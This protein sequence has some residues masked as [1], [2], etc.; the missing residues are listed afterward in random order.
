MN[1]KYPFIPIKIERFK[2]Q[3]VVVIKS[4]LRNITFI[5]HMISSGCLSDHLRTT[6]LCP[7]TITVMH[8]AKGSHGQGLCCLLVLIL[9]I[10]SWKRLWLFVTFVTQREGDKSKYRFPYNPFMLQFYFLLFLPYKFIISSP[11]VY[12]VTTSKNSL[13]MPVNFRKG[14]E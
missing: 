7:L 4:N 3:L 1:S 14:S 12:R 11:M 8:T 9:C 13:M 6:F 2:S 10:S 5:S